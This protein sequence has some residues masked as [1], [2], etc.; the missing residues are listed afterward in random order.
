[1]RPFQP[2]RVWLLGA[3][4]LGPIAIRGAQSSSADD[5]AAFRQ[6]R[7]ITEPAA[8]VEALQRF[9]A[10]HPGGT[11]AHRAADLELQTLLRSFPER[12]AAIHTLAAAAVQ[13]AAPGLDRWSE[14]A[15]Q[16]DG[17]A[18]AGTTGADLSDAK[19]WARDAVGQMTE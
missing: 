16:A 12:T 9:I 1:M 11:L 13:S 4:V 15:R 5:Q 3:L 10:Q 6:A 18:S 19:I 8:R 17:L 2:M 7:A 14:E